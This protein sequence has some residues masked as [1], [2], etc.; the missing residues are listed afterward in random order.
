M[1]TPRGRLTV[2]LSAVPVHD[3]QGAFTGWRG[4]ARDVTERL[5]AAAAAR[6]SEA[7]LHRLEAAEQANRGKSEFLSR[8]SHELR[9]PLNGIL[10]FM[11]VMA[12]DRENALA[13]EQRRRLEGA[14]RASRHLLGLVDDVLDL[15]RIERDD[16]RLTLGGVDLQRVAAGALALVAPLAQT[17]DVRLPGSPAETCWV[18]AERRALE[19]VLMNLLSNAIK[20]NRRGGAVG[21]EVAREAHRLRITVWDEGPGLTEAQ[22]RQLFQPF[23]RL[24][25]ERTRAEGT[26]L[27]LVIAR[28]LA[29]AMGGDVQA[30]SRPGAGSR[31]TLELDAAGVQ[32]SDSGPQTLDSMPMPLPD[33]AVPRR[34]LYIEDEPLNAMLMEEVFRGQPGWRLQVERDGA[35]GMAAARTQ[36]PDLL[37]IDMNLP[38]MTGIEIVRELRADPVTARLRCIALSADAMPDQIGSARAAGFD[39][40]WT[41]PIDVRRMLR[42]LARALD[43]E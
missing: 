9:T 3:E 11:E 8:V 36:A 31:F 41:K 39:D 35:R 42:A 16:F 28:Q 7:T 18:R 21:L 14:Q 26:G 6:E 15:T 30:A 33:D 4:T 1:P 12:L 40:Y 13:P 10:G 2:S 38:D 5:R 27:G 22:R 19:Q 17:H 32:D 20:Y 29:R 34:V 43:G 25:A 24:G 37:L 23:N